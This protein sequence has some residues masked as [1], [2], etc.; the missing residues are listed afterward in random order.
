MKPMSAS[1]SVAFQ[2]KFGCDTGP[3]ISTIEAVGTAC[4][5]MPTETEQRFHY[6]L[7]RRASL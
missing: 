6:A 3:F 5:V 7:C 2:L 1:F 4:S